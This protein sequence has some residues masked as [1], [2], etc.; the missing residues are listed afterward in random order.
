MIKSAF[1]KTHF[2]GHFIPLGLLYIAAYM[3][4]EKDYNVKILDM[5]TARDYNKLDDTLKIF[6]PDLV[7]ITS[8]TYE[9][10]GLTYL[11]KYIKNYNPKIHINLG[12]PHLTLYPDE[13]LKFPFVDSIT[14]G[15]GEIAFTKLAEALNINQ[16]PVDIPGIW[17]KNNNQYIK[18][19]SPAIIKNLDTL[20]FPDRSFLPQ[21][22]YSATAHREYPFT[23]IVGSRGCPYKCIFCTMSTSIYRYRSPSNLADEVEML[24]KQGYKYLD[25]VE[26]T[27]NVSKK[28]VSN[29][30]NEF[31]SRNLTIKWLINGRVDIIDDDIC[32][33]LK[34]AG[35]DKIEFGVESFAPNNL[36]FIKKRINIKQIEDSFYLANKYGIKTNADFIIGFP[37]ETIKDIKDTVKYAIKLNPNY[38]RFCILTPVPKTELYQ[39][40]IDKGYFKR[41]YFQEYALN[42]S[43]DFA[44]IHCSNILTFQQLSKIIKW[45]YR[46]FYLR[47]GKIYEILFETKTLKEFFNKIRSSIRLLLNI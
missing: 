10:F 36:D 22:Y 17:F 21:Q 13:T 41:D 31:I 3:K 18:N 26:G 6:N 4:K 30:C 7:G 24:S 28:W 47:I 34:K 45:S 37:E 25:F 2:E 5:L 8:Y 44:V 35:C 11:C 43:E 40:M 14:I 23:T 15:D 12:G 38:A 1:P 33:L 20:P 42:P 16:I 19:N 32:N 29:V 9:L 39:W 27:F 46:K